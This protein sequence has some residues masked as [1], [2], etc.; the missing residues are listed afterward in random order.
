MLYGVLETMTG[1]RSFPTGRNTSAYSDTP[2]RIRIGTRLSSRMSLRSATS[3]GG[4]LT[5]AVV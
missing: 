4:N 1:Y 2:S 5:A 3:G